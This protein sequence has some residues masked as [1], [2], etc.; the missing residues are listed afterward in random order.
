MDS[1]EMDSLVHLRFKFVNS[2]GLLWMKVTLYWLNRRLQPQQ[3]DKQWKNEG[4]TTFPV[5]NPEKLWFTQCSAGEPN[6]IIVSFHLMSF[7]V[8]AFDNGI[9]E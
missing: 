9:T 2:S 5:E 7:I 1:R 3:M 8:V 4:N 6:K